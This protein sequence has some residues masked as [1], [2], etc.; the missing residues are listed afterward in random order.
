MLSGWRVRAGLRP[1][2]AGQDD[3]ALQRGRLAAGV[4]GFCFGPQTG[5][6]SRAGA[7]TGS[8]P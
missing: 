4:S 6:V 5:P 7:K 8:D 1:D 2:Q 3:L